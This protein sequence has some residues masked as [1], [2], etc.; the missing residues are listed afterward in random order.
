MEGS[1]SIIGRFR[2][3]L[4]KPVLRLNSEGRRKKGSFSIVKGFFLTRGRR[5]SDFYRYD[6]IG[7]RAQENI[8]FPVNDFRVNRKRETEETRGFCRASVKFGTMATR[9][10]GCISHVPRKVPR[11]GPT[12][13]HYRLISS[14]LRA[15]HSIAILGSDYRILSADIPKTMQRV[16]FQAGKT[17][18]SPAATKK[19]RNEM[20]CARV[21]LPL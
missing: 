4:R 14:A 15:R 6:R 20:N 7:D 9:G 3:Q 12:E 1:V 11:L 21:S 8:N 19:I 17:A 18:F 10:R 5:N 13:L 2:R 16:G